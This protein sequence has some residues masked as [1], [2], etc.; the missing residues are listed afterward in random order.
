ME[1]VKTQIY[2]ETAE[3]LA[4]WTVSG[5]WLGTAWANRRS[6]SNFIASRT[7][8][9]MAGCCCHLKHTGPALDNLVNGPNAL[10]PLADRPH[11]SRALIEIRGGAP[12]P[13]ASTWK[14][15]SLQRPGR[16]AHARCLSSSYPLLVY[17]G[18]VCLSPWLIVSIGPRKA[19]WI[20]RPPTTN[21][22]SID[23]LPPEQKEQ[24]E[25]EARR[26]IRSTP[27]APSSTQEPAPPGTPVAS[28]Q[29]ASNALSAALLP[30]CP[31]ALYSQY[32]SALHPCPTLT[33]T[34]P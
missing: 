15:A 28:S 12:P 27:P 16:F 13:R 19:I 23:P 29:A 24:Q 20:S 6:S 21:R 4:H 3:Q 17:A 7:D 11:A 9:G 18:V 22:T 1:K 2:M 25:Q 34:T 8:S 26:H 31:L 33:L 14:Q 5:A 10:W 30:C 32:A